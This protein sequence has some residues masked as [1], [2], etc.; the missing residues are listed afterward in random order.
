MKAAAEAWGSKYVDLELDDGRHPALL[1]KGAVDPRTLKDPLADPVVQKARAEALKVR[2]GVWP[3]FF[4][5]ADRRRQ[6]GAGELR[7]KT[8]LSEVKAGVVPTTF[9]SDDEFYPLDLDSIS[10]EHEE[11][12][13]SDIGKSELNAIVGRAHGFDTV[14]P[15]KLFTKLISIWCPPNGIVLDAFAGSGTT[16]HAVVHLNQHGANRRF[17][18]RRAGPAREGRLLCPHSHRRPAPPRILRQVGG[19]SN[20]PAAGW[21]R[22]RPAWQEGRRRRAARDGAGRDGRYR[23]RVPLRREASSG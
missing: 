19:W 6:P 11:S 2:K 18:P 22:V 7:F 10:W 17:N 1:L 12:G 21:V 13:T 8:Y 9:W 23:H 15:L 20:G 14:K 3:Q 4:W 16:G 5:R